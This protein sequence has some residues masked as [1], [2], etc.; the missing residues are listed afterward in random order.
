LFLPFAISLNTSSSRAANSDVGEHCVSDL[1]DTSASTIFGS[2]T[3]PARG[4]RADRLHQLLD[5]LHPL[6]Q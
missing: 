4:H 1:A 6:L 5:V 3:D 2:I